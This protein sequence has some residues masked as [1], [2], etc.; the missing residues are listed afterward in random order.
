MPSG[1]KRIHLDETESTNNICFEE[2][3]KGHKTIIITADKQTEGRGR[4]SKQW[5][6]PEGNIYFS[7]GFSTNNIVEGLSVK[8]GL[9]V[10]EILNNE[11][12]KEILLKWPND[13]IYSNKKIGGILV[14]TSS[15]Q[16]TYQ[17]VIGIGINLKIDSL[18][19]H[20]GDL[21]IGDINNS[22][23]EQIINQMSQEFEAF[24][25]NDLQQDWHEKWNSL[26]AHLNHYVLI[27]SSKEKVKFLGVNQRGELL[28]KSEN[29]E[30][31]ELN[32]SSIKVE[33]LY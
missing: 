30:I 13:L 4:N 33:G 6:S 28:G 17:V 15:Y 18:E 14:E 7:F 22:F 23:K 21:N 16:S 25:H 32:E 5:F 8:A 12:E 27:E 10:A 24:S 9:K 19:E 3:N 11:L 2:L 20:W 1:L 29:G 31:I 26:C